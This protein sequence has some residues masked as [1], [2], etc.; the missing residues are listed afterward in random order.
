MIPTGA[1]AAPYGDRLLKRFTWIS[2]CLPLVVALAACNRPTETPKAP[3]VATA[4]AS[5]RAGPVRWNAATGGFE[6]N[7][8]PMKAARLWTFDGSTDGFTGVG[9]IVAPA[10]GQGLALKVVDPTLRSPKGLNVPGG[11]YPLVLVRLTRTAPG[12]LW[13]GALYYSTPAHPEVIGFFG[14]PLLGGKPVLG[15]TTTMI[16]DMANQAN[17][18]PDWSQSTIDHL[19]IDMED[20]AGGAFIIHQIAVVENPDPAALAQAAPSPAHKSLKP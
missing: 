2:L 8:K 9:S 16:Y 15:E 4:P 18:A 3:D 13:D 10:P 19:R 17:G 1:P 7:G 6:L 5:E 14:K 12:A 20:K 11:Q